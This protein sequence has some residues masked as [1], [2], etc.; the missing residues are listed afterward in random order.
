MHVN[1]DSEVDASFLLSDLELRAASVCV[2]IFFGSHNCM[3]HKWGSFWIVLFCQL[4]SLM[5]QAK[6]SI[7]H[8]EA[9]A[10]ATATVLTTKV[11]SGPKRPKRNPYKGF[12]LGTYFILKMIVTSQIIT[13]L[14]Y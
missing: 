6:L 12:V 3:D 13:T 9:Q 10:F 1:A 2:L 5:G 14:N 8:V 7:L 11:E 4:S